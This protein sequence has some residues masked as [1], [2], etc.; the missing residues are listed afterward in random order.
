MLELQDIEITIAGKT[1][2]QGVNFSVFPKRVVGLVGTNGSGKSSLLAVIMGQLSP[3][4]GEILSKKNLRLVALEQ[5]IP[6]LPLSA[7]EYTLSGDQQLFAVL[8]GIEQAEADGE[9]ER[10]SEL[11]MEL[12]QMNGYDAEA[13]AA[14]ILVGLGFQEHELTQQI[15]TFS[16]GWRMRLN[17]AKCLFTPSDLLLLDEPTNH[18]DLE[19]ILWLENYI[20]MYPGGILLVS[21][22]RDFMDNTCTH[23]A[24]IHQKTVTTYTGNYSTYEE[25][26]AQALA[27][28]QAHYASQQTLIAQQSVFIDRFRF[29]SS[30]ARQ[31][32][33]RLKALERMEKVAPVLADSPFKF[34]FFKNDRLPNPMI[35]VSKADFGYDQSVILNKV[36]LS[37]HAGQR[38]GL[39]GINGAGKSTYIKSLLGVIKPIKG[40]V[41]H[42]SGLRIGYFAQHQVDAL[43]LDDTAVECLASV[44]H[45]NA[46][47]SGLTYL[48]NFGFG[49]EQACTRVGTYSGGEKSRLALALLI[50]QKPNILFLDE[51]TNHLDLEMRQSLSMALQD[52]DGTLIL[53]SHDRQLMRTLVDELF[54]IESGN[55]SI[56]QGS[57]DDYHI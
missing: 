47:R 18:L 46:D 55:L 13:R 35:T 6:S 8:K 32:Q 33:S 53:V 56:F 14:K 7:L 24:H 22:D 15:G 10:L 31:V 34:S 20:K 12:D 36:N 29:K 4:A 57:I 16:G 49:K 9:M 2:M 42:A 50:Y 23:I 44:G 41:E 25:L 54:I 48:G 11:Y 45:P 1:L 43:P 26:R 5:E 17:L 38:I 3:A 28:Q 21:H 19:T 30:K 27:A 37:I 51:P 39:L 40:T 52:Y